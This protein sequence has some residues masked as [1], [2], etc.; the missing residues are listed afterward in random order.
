VESLLA[1]KAE[2]DAKA[3]LGF[4]PLHRAA[5]NGHKDVVELLLVREAKVNAKAKHG[6]TPLHWAADKG[7]KEVVELL[8]RHGGHE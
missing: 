7:H 2:I 8:R 3:N 6:F 1:D 5:Q 4:T